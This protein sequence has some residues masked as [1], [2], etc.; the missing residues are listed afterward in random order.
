MIQISCKEPIL[1][2]LNEVSKKI[3]NCEKTLVDKHYECAQK[4]KEM[5]QKL[6]KS[7]KNL[8]ELN[9]E[10][11]NTTENF[12]QEQIESKNDFKKALE[13]E[14]KYKLAYREVQDKKS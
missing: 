14:L 5:E 4:V 7:K 11:Y 10:L 6:K 8:K 3:E 9:E 12:I 1:Q 13:A 2:D